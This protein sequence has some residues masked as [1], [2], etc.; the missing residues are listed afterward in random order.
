MILRRYKGFSIRGENQIYLDLFNRQ[1]NVE[2]EETEAKALAK[3]LNTPL[4]KG[5]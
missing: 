4:I 5:K 1:L 2:W 3:L